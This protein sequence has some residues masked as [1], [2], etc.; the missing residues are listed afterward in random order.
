M[1]KQKDEL[2][3]EISQLES[4]NKKL[5]DFMMKSS[6]G[7]GVSAYSKNIPMLQ[8]FQSNVGGAT[9]S[10]DHVSISDSIRYTG[11]PKASGIDKL[12]VPGGQNTSISHANY[13]TGSKGLTLKQ[14]KD[15]I[16]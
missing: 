1:R 15:V 11:A 14:L 13:H 9:R 12:A 3:G 8:T 16:E 6:K 4:H 2:I 10:R 7:E 5:T